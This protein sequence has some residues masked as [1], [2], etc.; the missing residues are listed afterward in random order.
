MNIIEQLGG[1]EKAKQALCN[2]QGS[3]NIDPVIHV[4]G[5][6][7]LTDCICDA[8]LQYRKDHNIFEIGDRVVSAF[9]N[10]RLFEN[11]VLEIAEFREDIN[12]VEAVEGNYVRLTN[13]CDCKLELLRHASDKEIKQ[14]YRNE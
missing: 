4:D 14:G 12:S 10:V 6:Q 13:G 7:I 9:D 5:Q 8:M 2:A 1:Y 3:G 11:S